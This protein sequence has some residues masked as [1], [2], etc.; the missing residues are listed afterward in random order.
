MCVFVCT[1]TWYLG[2]DLTPGSTPDAT[3]L[4]LVPNPAAN[5][6]AASTDEALQVQVVR[7]TPLTTFTYTSGMSYT[8]TI[9]INSASVQLRCA[10][11]G[12][13][14]ATRCRQRPDRGP[15]V[16]QQRRTAVAAPFL[17]FFLHRIAL[18]TKCCLPAAHSAVSG[19]PPPLPQPIDDPHEDDLCYGENSRVRQQIIDRRQNATAAGGG[20]AV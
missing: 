6:V 4:Q 15:H 14:L 20:G 18:L 7:L 11:A 10:H 17:S 9:T 19:T 1:Q 12:F 8:Q 2:A 13:F 5:G 3:P 16:V